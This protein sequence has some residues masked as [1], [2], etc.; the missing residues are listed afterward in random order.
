MSLLMMAIGNSF[1]ATMAKLD[2]TPET[3]IHRKDE[4]MNTNKIS[5]RARVTFG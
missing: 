5:G 4:L 3:V 2:D 1:D